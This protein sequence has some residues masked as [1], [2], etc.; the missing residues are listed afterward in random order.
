[1]SQLA[2]IQEAALGYRGAEEFARRTFGKDFEE[3]QAKNDLWNAYASHYDPAQ[4]TATVAQVDSGVLDRYID[5]H[6]AKLQG[7]VW[8]AQQTDKGFSGLGRITRSE[9]S[10]LENVFNSSARTLRAQGYSRR[11]LANNLYSRLDDGAR[12]AILNQSWWK[13]LLA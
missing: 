3:G 12:R 13:A 1:M 2:P 4:L 11:D 6:G 10:I 9:E 7:M 8:M 5:A